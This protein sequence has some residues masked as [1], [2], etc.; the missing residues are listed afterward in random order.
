MWK[1]IHFDSPA[2]PNQEPSRPTA[3]IP[4]YKAITSA[5]AQPSRQAIIGRDLVFVGKITSTE[6]VESL[7]IDGSVEGSINLPSSL[8][9]VGRNGQ[10]T[11]DIIARDIVVMGRIDGNATA[12]SRME[13]RAGGDVEGEIVA[14]RLRI[15]DGAFIQGSINLRESEAEPEID[16]E[17]ATDA[18]ELPHLIRLQP[19]IEKHKRERALRTA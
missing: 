4:A 13:I 12:L 5:A 8:V 7:L 10:V 11:A 15:E 19:H 6:P 17:A 2:S 14:L 1:P 3:D 18:P 9:T 16:M